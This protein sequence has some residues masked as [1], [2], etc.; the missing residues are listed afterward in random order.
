MM[1]EHGQNG[2]VACC[3]SI[4]TQR[5]TFNDSSATTSATPN[6]TNSLKALAGAVLERNT[7]RNANATDAEKQRNFATKNR[8]EK[9]H[10]VA[11]DII[12]KNGW[13]ARLTHQDT[14]AV[15]RWLPSIGETDQ[16]M[17][18]DVLE[19]CACNPEALAYYLKRAEEVP[20]DDR[21]YCR[22]CLNLN[23]RGYCTLQRFRPVDDLPRRC[24]DFNTDRSYHHATKL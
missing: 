23:S 5:A 8:D 21:Q 11:A 4:P 13:A 14:T 6:A 2:K 9:L 19:Y 17:I 7:Q 10:S 15:L 18:D 16:A 1:I 12:D 24:E 20:Y 22:E 3:A